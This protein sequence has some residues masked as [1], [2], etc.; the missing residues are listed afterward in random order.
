MKNGNQIKEVELK[1]TLKTVSEENN[2][3][4]K[5]EKREYYEEGSFLNPIKVQFEED[6][7]LKYAH[8]EER[9]VRTRTDATTSGDATAAMATGPKLK[10]AD[11]TMSIKD[12]QLVDQG[13]D[14]NETTSMARKLTSGKATLGNGNDITCSDLSEQEIEEEEEDP[15]PKPAKRGRKSKGREE[16]PP[17][18]KQVCEQRGFNDVDLEYTDADFLKLTTFKLFQQTYRPRIQA[19]NPKI[20]M[21]KLVMLVA[22]K[23]REFCCLANGKKAEK[24]VKELEEKEGA[25]EEEDHLSNRGRKSTGRGRK[26]KVEEEEDED[27][28]EEDEEDSYDGRHRRSQGMRSAKGKKASSASEEE[29]KRKE[30]SDEEFENMLA[31]AEDSM[32]PEEEDDEHMEVCR[33]CMDGGVVLC[34]DSCPNVYHIRCL[35][36]PLEEYPEHEWICPRCARDPLPGK[37]D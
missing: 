23:W 13:H 10:V 29:E 26:K 11:N 7:Q 27:D 20:P 19:E 37:L 34:C 8:C 22:A 17:T 35:E 15:N 24:P 12:K 21:S 3:P 31:E 9:E 36:P 25:Q 30:D 16:S 33:I 5:A 28:Y 1:L 6:N 18:A 4:L 32:A 2:N 14:H